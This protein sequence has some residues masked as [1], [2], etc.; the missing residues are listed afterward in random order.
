MTFAALGKIFFTTTAKPWV[1]KSGSWNV[2]WVLYMSFDKFL[3][4]VESCDLSQADKSI[5]GVSSFPNFFF[6]LSTT[7]AWTFCKMNTLNFL[8]FTS[9]HKN[10]EKCLLYNLANFW[11]IKSNCQ[12]PNSQ[13]E[14]DHVTQQPKATCQRTCRGPWV[15]NREIYQTTF[16]LSAVV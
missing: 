6:C 8:I 10:W 13:L 15:T 1:W 9:H 12:V 4:A 5:I 11:M 14:I 16:P 7:E 2:P 3:L